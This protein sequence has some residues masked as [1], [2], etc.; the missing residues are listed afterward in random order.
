MAFAMIDKLSLAA[1]ETVYHFV[2]YMKVFGIGFGVVLVVMIILIFILAGLGS[3]LKKA[4][5]DAE[6]KE[7]LPAE[8]QQ[9][10]SLTQKE[11]EAE[12]A[13]ITAAVCMLSDTP[14]KVRKI[15]RVVNSDPEFVV[16]KVNR[17]SGWR[18]TAIREQVR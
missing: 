9:Q 6:K 5:R 12:I 11:D 4:V 13:A 18:R 7:P 2:D 8:K 1:D 15:R 17:D 10:I 14:V 16:R 3:M